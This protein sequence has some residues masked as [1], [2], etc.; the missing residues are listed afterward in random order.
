MKLKTRI[1]SVILLILVLVL[2]LGFSSCKPTVKPDPDDPIVPSDDPVTPIIETD[3]LNI[4]ESGSYTINSKYVQINISAP[5]VTLTSGNVPFINITSGSVTLN[6]VTSARVV[7]KDNVHLII[8]ENSNVTKVEVDGNN[9]SIELSHNLE[10]LLVVE[11]ASNTSV[12]LNEANIGLVG[13]ASKATFTGNGQILTV[14]TD[15]FSYYDSKLP[16]DYIAYQTPPYVSSGGSRNINGR[17]KPVVQTY[18][19]EVHTHN[20]V[21]NAETG[22]I[23]CSGCTDTITTPYIAFLGENNELL[24]QNIYLLSGSL[25]SDEVTYNSSTNSLTYTNTG[26]ARNVVIRTNGGTLTVN[27]PL[28]TVKHYGEAQVVTLAAVSVN[29]Y[30]ENGSVDQV[31]IKKGR[32][33]LTNAEEASVGTVYLQATGETYDNI[34]IATQ[35]GAELPDMIARDSVPLPTGTDTKTVVTIQSNVDANGAN[36]QKTET[37]NLYATSGTIGNDVYEATNGYNVSNLALLVVEASSTEAQAQAAEQIS[38]AEVL[39]TVTESK[40]AV[41][42]DSEEELTAALDAKAKYIIVTN[43]F[44]TTKAFLIKSSTIIEGAKLSDGTYPKIISKATTQTEKRGFRVNESNIDVTLRNLTVDV[45]TNV[46][47]DGG[48][49]RGLQIDSNITGIKL[50][51]DNCDI[52][53]THYAFNV[54][55]GADVEAIFTNSHLLGYGALNLWHADYVVK[56]SNCVLEGIQNGNEQFGVVVLEGDTTGKTDL[57]STSVTVQINNS[58]LIATCNATSGIEAFI[59]FNSLSVANT[60]ALNNCVLTSKGQGRT[61]TVYDSGTSNKLYFDNEL[62]DVIAY[63]NK[64]FDENVEANRSSVAISLDNAVLYYWIEANDSKVGGYY[65]LETIFN[66]SYVMDG[67]YVS[68]M[69]NIV[70]SNNLAGSSGLN[71]GDKFTFTTNGY[72][73]TGGTITLGANITAVSDS[74]SL[75]CFVNSDGSVISAVNNGN[76]TY[77]YTGH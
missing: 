8:N 71:S 51:V 18:T 39:A 24:T 36:A 77:S 27:A 23:S 1:C 46:T 40:S 49:P 32:L 34:I 58:E 7:L 3:T 29:S 65:S 31:N 63:A 52:S 25:P 43:S 48:Y 73:V 59:G 66:N 5:N 33:V 11:S 37:I 20:Y 61:K 9:S 55:N 12:K 19:P 44:D 42:V 13:L 56:V 17:E 2:T 74:S 10:E 75:S 26:V 70:L 53:A 47:S 35:S 64:L 69:E 30:Y 28:D 4:T 72:T 76:G 38:N 62:F 22:Y 15:N 6:S 45:R 16:V 50:V 68:L 67:E 57:H 54:C 21:L 14:V 41:E 60:V